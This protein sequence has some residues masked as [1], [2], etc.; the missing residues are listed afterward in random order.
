MS[1]TTR[2]D[3]VDQ[4]MEEESIE[5]QGPASESMYMDPLEEGYPSG[6]DPERYVVLKPKFRVCRCPS[7]TYIFDSW[8][9]Q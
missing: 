2:D 7:Y 3:H 8:R 1:V 9:G 6:L 5:K 4:P